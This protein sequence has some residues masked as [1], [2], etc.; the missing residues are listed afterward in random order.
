MFGLN[1]Y[2]DKLYTLEWKFKQ[3]EKKDLEDLLFVEF[4]SVDE[5]THKIKTIKYTYVDVLLGLEE[6]NFKFE[7]LNDRYC[8]KIIE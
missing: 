7:K 4:E 1:K 8:I 2:V 3:S 6:L 5:N